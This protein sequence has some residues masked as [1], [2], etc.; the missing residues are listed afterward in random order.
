MNRNRAFRLGSAKAKHLQ[1]LVAAQDFGRLLRHKLDSLFPKPADRKRVSDLLDS[2]EFGDDDLEPA[3]V[4]LAILRL[5][6]AD[7]AEIEDK[8]RGALE[9]SWDMVNWAERPAEMDWGAT[10]SGRTKLSP[11]DLSKI[12]EQDR[13][14]FEHWLTEDE[15]VA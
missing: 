1:E 10:M 3:R 8:I 15:I 7:F 14:Q 4:R 5:A 11:S 13:K 6:G 2:Y 9:D 12:Q